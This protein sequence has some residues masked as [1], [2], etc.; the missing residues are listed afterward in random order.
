M[1]VAVPA[2]G[3]V[4]CGPQQYPFHALQEYRRGQVVLRAQVGAHG[5]LV[6]PVV[7]QPSSDSYLDAGALDA[8]HHCR[9]PAQAPGSVVRLVVV[10]DLMNGDDYLPRGIVTV[11][12]AP[13]LVK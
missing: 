5:T 2:P 13:P 6:N 8:M 4:Q 9:I 3:G 10:Y 12:P 1:P 11:L 7:E